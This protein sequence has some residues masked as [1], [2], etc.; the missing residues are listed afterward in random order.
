MATMATVTVSLPTKLKD[1]TRKL[2]EKGYYAS[3][4]DAV[5]TALRQTLER[6]KYDLWAEEAKEDLQNGEA[7]VLR[8]AK[9]IDKLFN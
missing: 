6:S 8:D 3:I 9:D 2:V 1:Q 5:R 4:S 7:L